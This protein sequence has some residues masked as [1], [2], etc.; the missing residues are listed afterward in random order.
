MTAE[1]HNIK[2][3][4]NSSKP[5]QRITILCLHR[6]WR[7]RVVLIWSWRLLLFCP[8]VPILSTTTRSCNQSGALQCWILHPW[9]FQPFYTWPLLVPRVP[10]RFQLIFN[11]SEIQL[12]P[13]PKEMTLIN[14]MQYRQ[15]HYFKQKLTDVTSTTYH[16]ALAIAGESWVGTSSSSATVYFPYTS[17][18]RPFW[19]FLMCFS[20]MCSIPWE[21]A[22]FSQ[23][24]H[25]LS[26]SLL[27]IMYYSKTTCE[28]KPIWYRKKPQKRGLQNRETTSKNYTTN[29]KIMPV[30]P[31]THAYYLTCLIHC[32]QASLPVF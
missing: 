9:H 12:L 26:Y 7:L 27:Q 18:C 25:V 6:A 13:N 30:I 11:L 10:E 20:K 31:L 15:P 1:W 29:F 5:I 16:S 3:F 4:A 23:V 8:T 17:G 24:G 14:H 19:T 28:K 22:R 21:I 2:L 32:L